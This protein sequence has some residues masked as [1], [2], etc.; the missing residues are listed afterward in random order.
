MYLACRTRSDISITVAQLRHFLVN[1][2]RNTGMLVSGCFEKAVVLSITEAEYM[3]LS[4]CVKEVM[5]MR[6][7][8]KDFGSNQDG[9]TVIYENNQDY[10][11]DGYDDDERSLTHGEDST[12]DGERVGSI[13]KD[14]SDDGE[15]YPTAAGRGTSLS[16]L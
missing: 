6:L 5:W 11:G 8:L 2:D 10:L 16:A 1:L 9:G 15:K 3:V 13:S 14:S 4:D 7:L 12:D